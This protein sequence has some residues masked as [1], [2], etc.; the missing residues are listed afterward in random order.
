[1]IG[2]DMFDE[3]VKPELEACCRKLTN[4][5]YHLDGPGQLPHLDSLLQIEELAGVQWV[6]G[7]GQ[8][9]VTHWPEVYRKIHEAGKL[10]QLWGGPRVLD[11]VAEQVGTAEGII[12]IGGAPM[13]EREEIIEWMAGYGV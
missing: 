5:F 2:P 10:I 13:E 11:T 7:A 1:M 9:D 4:A 6:P 3:F 12:V 8:P